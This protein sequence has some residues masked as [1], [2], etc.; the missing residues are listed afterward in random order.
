MFILTSVSFMCTKP[1]VVFFS[2]LHAA[3][4]SSSRNKFVYILRDH[5]AITMSCVYK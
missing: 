3:E 4:K 1:V 2:Q 5:I